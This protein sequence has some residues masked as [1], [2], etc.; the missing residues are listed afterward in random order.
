MVR[1][2]L[3]VGKL[4]T[5]AHFL[6]LDRHLHMVS[7]RPHFEK[8]LK[9]LPLPPAHPG[10]LEKLVARTLE[11]AKPHARSE[12]WKNQWEYLLRNEI[13]KLAVCLTEA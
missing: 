3:C 8:L 4:D 10:Q 13:F 7:L 2:E 6:F 9:D 12:N 5:H 1:G 11:D